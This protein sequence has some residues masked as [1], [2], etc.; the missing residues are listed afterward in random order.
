MNRQVKT[1]KYLF[2][3]WLI[4]VTGQKTK[5]KSDYMNSFCLATIQLNKGFHLLCIVGITD[6]E[7]SLDDQADASC[8]SLFTFYKQNGL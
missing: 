3:I 1:V 4:A 8:F 2:S 6:D 5:P 7:A